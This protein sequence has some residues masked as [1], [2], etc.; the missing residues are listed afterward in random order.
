MISL[1]GK[2]ITV[3]VGAQPIAA[4]GYFEHVDVEC[5][6]TG[7]DGQKSSDKF[8]SVSLVANDAVSLADLL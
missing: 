2:E 3:S 4:I 7:R 1:V 8:T 5:A 6:R